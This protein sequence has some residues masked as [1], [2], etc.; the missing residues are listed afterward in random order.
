MRVVK[1]SAIVCGI[2]GAVLGSF[3]P[4]VISALKIFYTL[5]AAALVLPVIAGLYTRRVQA[6]SAVLS[7]LVSVVVTFAFEWFSKG[8]GVL[9]IPS[10]FFGVAAGAVV[11]LIV[12]ALQERRDV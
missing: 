6:R 4:T 7:M 11:M 2:A 9:G 12:N 3:L 8:Q 10:L 1:F 5:L